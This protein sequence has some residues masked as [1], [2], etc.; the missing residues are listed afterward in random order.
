M[1]SP[2]QG[3][4]D[5]ALT[6]V[7]LMFNNK[8]FISEKVAPPVPVLKE[9]AKYLVYGTDHLR[10][11][12]DL[13]RPATRSNQLE[14]STTF[15]GPYFCDGHALHD[16]VSDE[17]AVN[18][19][20]P[21][22]LEVDVTNTLTEAIFLNREVNLVS[23][24][25]AALNPTDL[26]A[27]TYANAWDQSGIDPIAV[28]DAAKETVQLQIARR[29]N[30]MVLS[31]PVFRAIRNNPNV[32]ARVS[33]ALEGIDKSL[34]TPQQ[35]AQLLEVDQVLIGEAVKNTAA[36][37]QTPSDAFVWGRSAF[38]CYVPESPGLRTPALAYQFTWDAGNLG[39]LVYTKYD[40]ERHA[41]RIEVMKYYDVRV[42]S[43]LC[44]VG[45]INASST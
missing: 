25:I 14:L 18:A 33:G 45:W 32:K 1:L 19:D 34:I 11:G 23:A 36:P 28:I 31:R 8:S 2:Q 12:I 22:D 5:V 38:L 39:S 42:V 4:I 40:D 43:A 24:L 35:L 21:I 37:N 26:S 44:G 10:A 30:T 6:N 13:R 29:P 16:Y 9:S 27:S 20:K 3:H 7:S 15:A 41:K 17:G